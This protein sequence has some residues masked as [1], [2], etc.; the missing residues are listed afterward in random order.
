MTLEE[1]LALSALFTVSMRIAS[2]GKR[3]RGDIAWRYERDPGYKLT[4][5]QARYLWLLVDL[6]RRQITSPDLRNWGA[7]VKLTGELPPIYRDGDHAPPAK[8]KEVVKVSKVL[9]PEL[10]P[11]PPSPQASLF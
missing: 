6:Y 9:A 10:Q 7:H 3:F 5:K 8:P 11:P 4:A 1:D 2:A